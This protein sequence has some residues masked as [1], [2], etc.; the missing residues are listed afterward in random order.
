MASGLT[1]LN[2]AP[3]QQRVVQLTVTG[4]ALAQTLRHSL[5]GNPVR[6]TAT[7]LANVLGLYLSA[8]V[9]YIVLKMCL[10]AEAQ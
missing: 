5:M 4:H 3:A 1:G 10:L 6:E 7:W 8:R 2:G 9:I